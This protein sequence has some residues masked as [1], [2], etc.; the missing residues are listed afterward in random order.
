MNFPNEK[1]EAKQP[2]LLAAMQII[3]I[4]PFLLQC[5]FDHVRADIRKNP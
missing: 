4:E 5:S 1:S 2:D 3:I